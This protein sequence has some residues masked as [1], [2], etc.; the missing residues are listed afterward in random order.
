MKVLVSQNVAIPHSVL[1]S[2]LR[3][4]RDEVMPISK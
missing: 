4:E 3:K 2:P 1:T